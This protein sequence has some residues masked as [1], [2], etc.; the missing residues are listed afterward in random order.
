MTSVL[1]AWFGC[2]AQGHVRLRDPLQGLHGL[3]GLVR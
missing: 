1:F 3:Q 2:L